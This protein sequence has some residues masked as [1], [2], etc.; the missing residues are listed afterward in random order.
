MAWYGPA[1]HAFWIIPD[2]NTKALSAMQFITLNGI[3]HHYAL[4][5]PDSAPVIVF[6]N[7]LGT[8]FR[9]WDGVLAA[10]PKGVRTLRYD[11]RGHG[12]TGAPDGPYRMDQLRDDL[13][14][15]CDALGIVQFHLVGLSVGGL[16]G[17][18]VALAAPDRIARMVLCDTAHKIGPASIWEERIKAIAADGLTS[19]ADEIMARWFPEDMLAREPDLFAEAKAMMLRTPQQGYLGVAAAI[20]DTDFTLQTPTIETPTLVMVGSEDKATPPALVSRLADL[21]P[22]SE[23]QQIAGAGHLPC[24]EQPI[25]VA[26]LISRHCSLT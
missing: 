21:M 13:L 25:R 2:K 15:L 17:Q 20:R 24:L 14:G 1:F 26:E 23:L 6:S 4:A 9:I 16:V 11:M 19:V 18:A 12:L 8:D 7:A 3:H 10:L 5:G 22:N